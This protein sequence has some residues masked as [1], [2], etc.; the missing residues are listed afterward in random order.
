MKTISELS[1]KSGAGR[2]HDDVV[3]I[4]QQVGSIAALA[5]DEQRGVGAR[6]AEAQRVKKRHDVLVPARASAHTR[7]ARAGTHGLDE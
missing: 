2:R 3:D 5:V 4:E 7:S 1:K 6:R